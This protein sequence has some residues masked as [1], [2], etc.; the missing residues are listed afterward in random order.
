M[1]KQK[2]LWEYFRWRRNEHTS[3]AASAVNMFMVLDRE[4][5]QKM[6]DKSSPEDEK[7]AENV[8]SSQSVENNFSR[9]RLSGRYDFQR[10]QRIGRSCKIS[11]WLIL[12]FVKKDTGKIRAGWTVPRYV[13]NAVIRNRLKR[14]MRE[15]LRSNLPKH[16][17]ICIDV[18]FIFLNRGLI[19]YKG[20]SHE[21]FNQTIDSAV[22]KIENMGPH[23]A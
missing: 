21:K 10:I 8:S 23:R 11:E 7:R 6:V 20:L 9:L 3:P 14:W 18:N 12:A 17:N 19:F 1:L 2:F 13:G 22:K 4:W 5:P 16:Q 15:K